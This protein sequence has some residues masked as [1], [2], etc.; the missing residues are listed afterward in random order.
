MPAP[1]VIRNLTPETKMGNESPKIAT[2]EDL[3]S[4]ARGDS[5]VVVPPGD[6]FSFGDAVLGGNFENG[7]LTIETNTLDFTEKQN[8]NPLWYVDPGVEGTLSASPLSRLK[9]DL[10]GTPIGNLDTDVKYTSQGSARASF[11]G[12]APSYSVP[13][14]TLGPGRGDILTN[15]YGAGDHIIVFSR[16]R[17]NFDGADAYAKW[18]QLNPEA[19]AWNIK[20]W[21][22]WAAQDPRNDIVFAYGQTPSE[23]GAP[24]ITPERSM[25]G[26][27]HTEPAGVDRALYGMKKNQWVSELIEL[28]QSSDFDAADGLAR[29]IANGQEFVFPN[30]VTKNNDGEDGDYVQFVIEQWQFVYTDT[31]FNLWH[32][33]FYLDDTPHAV[34]ITDKPNW[35]DLNAVIDPAIPLSWSNSQITAKP[36]ATLSGKYLY[37]KDGN[38]QML[39]TVGVQL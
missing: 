9:V 22:W 19:S 17:R 34:I 32:D 3:R 36:R 16:Y 8:P 24:R 12:Q 33:F 14:S 5:G 31:P 35:G 4:G 23:D 38:G 2:R 6:A 30:V 27:Y 39:N 11:V 1:I 29:H 18:Q 10:T 37:V 25:V 7:V 13:S 28:K 15:Q 20:R 26:V 21:R